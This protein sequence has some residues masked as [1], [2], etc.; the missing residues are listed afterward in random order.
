RQGFDAFLPLERNTTRR[1][2]KF[3]TKPRPMFP[4]Y[5]FVGFDP[6]NGHWRTINSTVGITRLVSF[7]TRPSAVPVDLI[8]ALKQHTQPDQSN[9]ITLHPGA[10]VQITAGPFAEFIAEIESLTPDRRVWVLIDMM[11]AKTRISTPVGHLREL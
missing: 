11:G 8:A 7:G 9:D 1:K 6:E 4:G 3:I 10:K 5:I 2:E